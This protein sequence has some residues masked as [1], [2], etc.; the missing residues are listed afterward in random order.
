VV[1]IIE[2][3]SSL[4]CPICSQYIDHIAS[5]GFRVFRCCNT[6]FHRDEGSAEIHAACG[7]AEW[8]AFEAWKPRWPEAR[9]LQEQWWAVEAK[10]DGPLAEIRQ[11][12]STIKDLEKTTT[13]SNQQEI[14][15][16]ENLVDGIQAKIQPDVEVRKRLQAELEALFGPYY[17]RPE[18]FW[19]RF[20]VGLFKK[21]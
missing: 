12:N 11:Y 7:V 1:S 14:A 13:E 3:G 6:I 2:S 21:H 20:L 4:V 8:Q 19:P 16:L 17:N 15:R 18:F 10:L 9:Q 5:K